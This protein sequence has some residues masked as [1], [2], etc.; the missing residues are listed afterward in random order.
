MTE[1][2]FKEHIKSFI[3]QTIDEKT[4]NKNKVCDKDKYKKVIKNT[5]NYIDNIE[6]DDMCDVQFHMMLYKYIKEKKIKLVD[7]ENFVEYDAESFLY[8]NNKLS[9]ISMDN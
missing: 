6:E 1:L 9:I 5:L 7:E 8:N 3:K 4:F 2:Q